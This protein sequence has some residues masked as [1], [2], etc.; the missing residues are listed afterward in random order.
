[1]EV[2]EEKKHRDQKDWLSV[3]RLKSPDHR[4]NGGLKKTVTQVPESSVCSSEGDF[5][6]SSQFT[7]G[8]WVAKPDPMLLRESETECIKGGKMHCQEGTSALGSKPKIKVY[9]QYRGIFQKY[10]SF[11]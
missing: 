2:K 11:T 3:F 5:D 10:P 4:H 1:M 6:G 8:W 9:G 7:A